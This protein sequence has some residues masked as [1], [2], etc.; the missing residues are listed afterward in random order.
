MKKTILDV[1]GRAVR[2]AGWAGDKPGAPC[3]P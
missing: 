3:A 1:V 2:L